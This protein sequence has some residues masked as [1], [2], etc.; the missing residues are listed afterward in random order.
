MGE[1]VE[2]KNLESALSL[3]GRAIDADVGPVGM[4]VFGQVNS[5]AVGFRAD[6]AERWYAPGDI[7]LAGQPWHARTSMVH[8]GRHDQAIVDPD[9]PSQ[10]AATAPGRVPQPVRFTGYEPGSLQGA[11]VWRQTFGSTSRFATL[12]RQGYG[13]QP[14]QTL[15][16]G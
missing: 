14:S 9:L 8:G 16:R 13:K 7:Y 15:G 5:G 12:Y 4:L 6:G 11:V 2:V 3:L 1:L 10:V